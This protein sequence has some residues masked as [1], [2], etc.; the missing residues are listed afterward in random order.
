[1]TLDAGTAFLHS[2]LPDGHHAIIELPADIPGSDQLQQPAYAILDKAMN[3]LWV[4]SQAW[5][6]LVTNMCSRRAVL[7]GRQYNQWEVLPLHRCH[8][9]PRRFGTRD[10]DP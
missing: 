4:A 5:I 3:G 2:D 1:M 8:T 7:K 9:K 6:K 10:L